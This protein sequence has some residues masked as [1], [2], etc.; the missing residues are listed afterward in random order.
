MRDGCADD[1]DLAQLKA[2]LDRIKPEGGTDFDDVMRWAIANATGS[3]GCTMLEQRSTL[4]PIT[5]S[6]WL[7]APATKGQPSTDPK[8][9]EAAEPPSTWEPVDLSD[10]LNGT[11]V[12]ELATLMPRSDGMGLLYPGR[13]HSFHGESESGKSLAAQAE[14]ARVLDQGGRVLYLDFESDHA[15]VTTRLLTMGAP[16]QAIR[17]RLDYVRPDA[18]LRDP[19]DRAAFRE[20]L[21]RTYT[22]AIVDGVTEALALLGS[23]EG[24]PEDRIAGFVAALPRRVARHTGAAVIQVDHVTKSTEGRGRFALGSQHKMNALDGAAYTVEVVEPLGLGLRGVIVLRIAKDR[25]GS[26]RPNCGAWRKSDR[27]QE[28]ARIIVDSRDTGRTTITVEPP[29][30][31][32]GG[33]DEQRVFRPTALMERV[34]RYLEGMIEPVSGRVV[35]DN[36]SGKA[37]VI[38]TALDV[39]VDEEFV[40]RSPGP[41]GAYMHTSLNGYRQS[42]DP[43]SDAYL[44]GD[45]LNRTNR[46]FELVTATATA[47]LSKTGDAGRSQEGSDDRVPGRTGTQWG[48]TGTQSLELFTPSPTATAETPDSP[49][50]EKASRK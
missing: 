1:S 42:A 19:R 12:A 10:V 43:R 8:D 35:T 25:P 29:S 32:V 46:D 13:L 14:A 36:V 20:I 39:L 37:P 31:R 50:L 11:Y 15:S 30:T 7:D 45:A 23:A 38:R 18:G 40:A 5:L 21:T 26:I 22:V 44:N 33:D 24:T 16:A 41:R 47:S 28:A 34:S 3:S 9:V 2:T 17:E 48:R 4:K 49:T 6:E 27:T